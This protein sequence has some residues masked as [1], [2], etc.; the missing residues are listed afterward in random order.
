MFSP[1]IKI[2]DLRESHDSPSKSRTD[3]IEIGEQKIHFA[4]RLMTSGN[5]KLGGD[6]LSFDLP[7][8]KTCPNC[9]FCTKGCYAK[10]TERFPA[11][12]DKHVTNFLITK[13]SPMK[14]L[15][16]IGGQLCKCKQNIVRIH[17]SGDFYSQEYLDLWELIARNFPS[18]SFYGYT[19][20]RGFFDFTKIDE[21]FNINIIDSIL[22]NG[23]VNFGS[24]EYCKTMSYI[25]N[26]PICPA[27]LGKQCMVDCDICLKCKHV[28]FVQH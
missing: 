4:P 28:L 13:H 16:L 19:K 9:K 1:K 27:Y 23:G 5:S 2:S 14:F 26:I 10:R 21:L 22:P 8:V 18:I 15:Q 24:L 11:V 20:T 6:V 3:Y 12:H 17:S 7:A 25:Y